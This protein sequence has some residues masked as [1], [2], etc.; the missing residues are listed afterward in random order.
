[1]RQTKSGEQ[2]F[3]ESEREHQ[4]ARAITDSTIATTIE[5]QH[6]QLHLKRCTTEAA[7]WESEPS[8]IDGEAVDWES[9]RAERATRSRRSYQIFFITTNQIIART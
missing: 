7:V 1:M 6:A 5:Q 4:V 3:G 9:E 8:S 2:Q